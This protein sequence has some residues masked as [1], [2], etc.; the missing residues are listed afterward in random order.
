MQQII[1]FG[2]NTMP[3][4][5]SFRRSVK[6]N[7]N[8]FDLRGQ[9]EVMRPRWLAG[10][11]YYAIPGWLDTQGFDLPWRRLK[12]SI[13]HSPLSTDSHVAWHL[14]AMYPIVHGVGQVSKFTVPCARGERCRP[15]NGEK[16][17]RAL[18]G[19]QVKL[20]P[21]F[22]TSFAHPRSRTFLSV[23]KGET[24]LVHKSIHQRSFIG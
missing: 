18:A 13:W 5:R 6:A 4:Y 17:S 10:C 2:Q 16:L 22:P 24:G 8:T 21:S 20:L 7:Y 23:D 19:H 1:S 15:R 12:H 14:Q 3:N 9:I 11:P